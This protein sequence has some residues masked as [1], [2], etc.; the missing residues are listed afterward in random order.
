[1]QKRILG[2]LSTAAAAKA[3]EQGRIDEAA[4]H[5]NKCT[6]CL[7]KTEALTCEVGDTEGRLRRGGDKM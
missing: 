4:E 5:P 1:M 6:K 2:W 7:L 3:M